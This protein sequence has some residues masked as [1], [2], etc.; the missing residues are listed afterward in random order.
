MEPNKADL[1]KNEKQ[2]RNEDPITGEPGAHPVGTGV[3]AV[4]GGAAAGALTGTVAGPLGTLVGTAVGAVVGGLA[5]KSVAEEIDPTVEADFWRG[6]YANRPY[7]DS[8]RKFE[9]YEPAYHAGMKAY[10][11]SEPVDFEERELSAREHWEARSDSTLT[12]DKARYAAEDA[13]QR[14]RNRHAK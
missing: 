9:D 8:D 11:P 2:L 3:G 7:Y 1:T 10:D 6:E 5:G 4:L 14:V 12:W 13:Y